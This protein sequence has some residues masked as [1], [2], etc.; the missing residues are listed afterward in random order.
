MTLRVRQL[1]LM[2]VVVH[3]RAGRMALIKKGGGQGSW[4]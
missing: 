2:V 3:L 4:R 1:L